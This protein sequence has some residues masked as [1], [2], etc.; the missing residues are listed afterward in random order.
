M[1][2]END[3]PEYERLLMMVR[4]YEKGTCT[5]L[6]AVGQALVAA[7]DTPAAEVVAA[8]KPAMVNILRARALPPPEP[9]DCYVSIRS[10]SGIDSE[11]RLEQEREEDRKA[12]KGLLVLHEYFRLQASQEESL[13]ADQE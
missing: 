4:E 12:Y 13:S 2:N 6:E 3:N 7:E 5:A 9:E 11:D 10:F 1:N 8:L